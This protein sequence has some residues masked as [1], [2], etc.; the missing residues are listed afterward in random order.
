M[1]DRKERA[2]ALTVESNDVSRHV[3]NISTVR[4]VRRH[5]WPLAN[6]QYEYFKTT[7]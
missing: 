4:R 3:S 5:L 6:D 2:I 1:K 7:E